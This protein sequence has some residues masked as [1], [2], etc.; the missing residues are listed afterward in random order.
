MA[1]KHDQI[2]DLHSHTYYSNCSQDD[3]RAVIQTAIDSGVS[4]LGIND[5]NY[6][7]A[8]RK[9]E[10]LAEM[11]ALAQEYKDEI[12]VL[13]GIE[14]ATIPECFDIK[15]QSEIANFDYCLIEHITTDESIV[16]GNLIEFCISL[17][18]PC[19]IAHTDL[20][21]YCKKYG[22]EPS[23]L[24]EQMAKHGI[25]WEMNVN[26]DS[27][28][29]YHEHEYVKIFIEDVEKQEIVK[30]SGLCISVG[31]DGHRFKDYDGARVR[32]MNEFLQ[33]NG[34]PT[35]ADHPVL[36]GKL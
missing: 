6:G 36:G 28:H 9:P 33:K 14:I 22:Y 2:I 15:R 26:Y 19:G 13:C 20:F 34:I 5:H 31:F 11:R 3:P 10:Y 16:G 29:S 35:L 4:V 7:I 25:F 1:K 27:V 21:A 12:T 8:S 32:K 18:I 24:F 23:Q 30:S 17:G